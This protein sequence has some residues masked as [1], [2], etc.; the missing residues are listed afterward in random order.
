[1]IQVQDLRQ[2]KHEKKKAQTDVRK[3]QCR[4]VV[5]NDN[6]VEHTYGINEGFVLKIHLRVGS[7]IYS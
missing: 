6:F 7:S 1:M 5:Q 3:E 2:D 4:V